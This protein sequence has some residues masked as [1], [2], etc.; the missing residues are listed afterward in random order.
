MLRCLKLF[1]TKFKSVKC[2]YD[3]AYYILWWTRVYNTLPHSINVD[4]S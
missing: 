1:D 3:Y 2:D 4:L